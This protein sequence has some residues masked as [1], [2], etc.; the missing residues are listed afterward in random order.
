MLQ[1]SYIEHHNNIL[2]VDDEIN[3]CKGCQR[4]FEEDGFITNYALTGEEGLE[5]A[6]HNDFDLIITD[7]K[8]P[9]INGMEVIKRIKQNQPDMPV[10]MITGYASVPTAVEAMK[11]GADDYIPKPF[12][13]D[14]IL[15]AVH[16]AINRDAVDTNIQQKEKVIK[17]SRIFDEIIEK[18]QVLS[19]LYRTK[20]DTNF[21]QKLFENGSKALKEY[22]LSDEAKAAI[23]SGDIKWIKNHYPWTSGE[24]TE[25]KLE[26]LRHR[27]EAEIW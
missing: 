23:V 24:L 22:D 3:V 13:P 26:Y 11:I 21:W 12:K 4:I 16:K 9:D 8:M 5:K 14:E 2:I 25:D 18:E 10:I 19:V 15:N 20:S 17:K 1:N 7:M 27:L 6:A